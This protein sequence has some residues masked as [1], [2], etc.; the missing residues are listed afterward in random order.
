M[1]SL[2]KDI[3][4]NEDEKIPENPSVFKHSGKIYHMVKELGRRLMSS[5]NPA[6]NSGY[7]DLN[8]LLEEF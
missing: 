7:N 3:F 2:L 4:L 1:D 8:N 5:S 6:I